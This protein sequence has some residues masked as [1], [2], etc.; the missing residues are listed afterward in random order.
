[1]KRI[2]VAQADPASLD[3]VWEIL[4]TSGYDVVL[5]GD[6]R[7]ALLKIGD[8]K[9]DLVILD[10]QMQFFDGLSVVR[11]L[12]RNPRF[13]GLPVV[14]L[15]A[16]AMRGDREKALEAGFDAYI[17]KPF[18]VRMLPQQLDQLLR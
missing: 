18:Q 12:R 8:T 9:P 16:C 4:T 3:L 5:V 11:E 6:G 10:L 14:A 1:M 13:R 17:A 7:A 2:L 15:T